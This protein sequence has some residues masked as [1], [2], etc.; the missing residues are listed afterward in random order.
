MN[1]VRDPPDD[2][3]DRGK[4]TNPYDPKRLRLSQRFGEG[5]DVRR[6]IVSMP[7]RKPG[8]Q[9][10]FRTY[11]DLEMWLET[12]VLELKE[13]RLSYLV[14]PSLAPYLPGEAVSKVL[15]PAIT[16]HQ[17]LFLYP[18]KL[19]DER[20]RHDEWNAVALEAAERARSRW[21]RLTANIGAGTYDVLEAMAA[22]SEP[23]WPEMPLQRMLSMAFKDRFVE[24]LDH[25]VLKRLRGEI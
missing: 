23:D 21:I 12:A 4:R 17:A 9:E 11:P 2:D 18:I 16:S 19:P 20:G 25:P 6:V 14:E 1:D 7:V 22:F 8:R 15:I 13:E 10:F 3:S 5:Q 24:T